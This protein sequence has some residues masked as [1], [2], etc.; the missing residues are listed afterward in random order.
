[1]KVII[2]DDHAL[3]RGG[4]RL[5][6]MSMVPGATV[7]EAG[8]F[9]DVLGCGDGVDDV[10]LVVLDLGMPGPPWQESVR[11]IRRK[12]PAVRLVV[13]SGDDRPETIR[14]VLG[15]GANGFIPKSEHPDVFT[16][17]MR[18]ILSGG[19]YFPVS[20][21]DADPE[22]TRAS[23]TVTDRQKTVLGLMALGLSNKQIARNLGLTEGTVKLHVAAILRG[24]GAANRTQ[25]VSL[26]RSMGLID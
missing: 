24:L 9:R 21:V 6:M 12:W 3:F 7:I 25:A 13:V 2:A 20:V 11:Q 8:D 23:G 5:Q 26:G 19:C 4:L 18:L 16:A 22:P 17:A 1:M 15:A 10:H 14:A